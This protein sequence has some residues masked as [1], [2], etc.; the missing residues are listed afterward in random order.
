VRDYG[1]VYSKFW[2]SKDIQALNDD[3]R[4]LALYLLSGPHGTIA[5]VCRLPDGYVCEDLKWPPKRVSKGFLELFRKGFAKRCETTDWVWIC[6]FLTWNTPENPNQWKAARKIADSVPT[7]CSWIAAF[8]SVFAV[9]A[10][11]EPPPESNGSGTPSEG[12]P[13]QEQDQEQYQEQKQKQELRAKRAFDPAAISG[14]DLEAW[15]RWIEYRAERKPAI[16][17][18]SLQEAAEELAAFGRDQMAVVKKSIAA[19]YQGLFAPKNGSGA[20]KPEGRRPKTLAELEAE[21][22]AADAQH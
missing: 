2:T 14:L 13:T 10:G 6:R 1:R 8:R 22:A 18:A 15:A 5:G 19:G 17:K 20:H 21:E 4:L 16:R 7:E 11:E 9:A 3:A 12:L